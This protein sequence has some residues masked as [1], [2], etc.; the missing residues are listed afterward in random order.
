MLSCNGEVA[1][2]PPKRLRMKTLS[3]SAACLVLA[4]VLSGQAPLPRAT[5]DAVGMS[6][7]RLQSAT[8]LLREFVADRQIAGAVAG[9]ARRG[10]VVYLEPVGLQSF[11]SRAPMTERSLFRIY[12]MTK[13]VTAVAVMMLNEEGKFELTD[14]VSK[15]LPEFKDVTACARNSRRP[16]SRR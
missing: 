2:H 6:A 8:A 5:P 14:P 11:E 15:H 10:K 1:S 3:I 12:S 13:A 7:D 16:F 4:A 9:V